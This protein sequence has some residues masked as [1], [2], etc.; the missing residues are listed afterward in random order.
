M[1]IHSMPWE[2][3]HTSP[4]S[5][6]TL[7]VTVQA[8][9][10]IEVVSLASGIFPEQ[11]NT[12][13]PCEMSMCISTAQARLAQNNGPEISVQSKIAHKMALV[14]CPCPFRLRRLAQNGC[15]GISVWH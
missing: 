7:T 4:S 5:V 14:T 8:R 3:K 15:G 9:C 6:A 11:L 10:S 2:S 12:K 13:L 1:V